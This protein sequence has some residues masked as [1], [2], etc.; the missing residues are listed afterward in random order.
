MAELAHDAAGPEHGW[1]ARTHGIEVGAV[2]WTDLA[3]DS[4][5]SGREEHGLLSV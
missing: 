1:R 4:V 5:N 3:L 2:Y